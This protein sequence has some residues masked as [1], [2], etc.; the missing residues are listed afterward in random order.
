MPLSHD[1]IRT[2]V[3]TYL[4]HH[5][6]ER[7]QLG[8]FL[9]ALDREADIAC[10]STFSGHVTCGAIVVDHLGRVLHVLHLASGK[11][12]APGGH[13]EP[14][15]ESLAGVALRELHEET[16]IPPD[17]VAPWPGYEDV[18]F[19]VDIHD[20]DARPGKGEPG[21]QHFDV[22]FLF[23]VRTAAEVPVV[24]QEEEVGGIEWR[25]LDRVASP[26]LREKLMKLTPTV[27]PGAS[28][29][30]ALIHNDRGEYLL[31]LRDYL[32]GQIWEPGMWSLLGGGREHQ[33]TTLEQTVRRELAEEAGLDIPDL[34]PFGTEYATDAAGT[35]VP[36][37]IYAGRWNGDPRE[38]RLTEG[39][40]LAWFAPADLHRLRIASTTSDLVRRHAASS[41][42]GTPTEGLPVPAEE[43][44]TRAWQIYGRSQ[45]ARAYTPPVPDQLS[46]TSWEGVGPGAEVLG[47]IA[48]R[49]VL[50]IGSGAGH[51]AVHLARAHGARVT[52][53][54]LS[55]TQH[56]RAVSTHTGHDG[57]EFVQGDVADYLAGAEPFHAAYAIGTL[58]FI[59]PHRSLPALRD[60]LRP[61]APLILSLLHTDLHGRGPSTEVA[62]REQMILLRDDPPLPTQMWVLAPHLW[63]DLLTEYG[64]RVEAID[65]L[66]H[67]DENASVIQQLIRA[68]RLPARPVR[69]SSRPR[70]PVAHAAVGVGAIIVS[71][72]GLLLGRHHRGTIEL[73]GGTVETGESF[74][75]AAVRELGEETGL[76]A[77]SEDVQLLGT[78][79]DH[80]EGVLRV[81]VGA[82]VHVWQGQPATQPNESIGEWAWYPLDQLPDGLFVCSAQILTAW[83]P[84]LNID[85]TP[86]HFTPFAHGSQP[87]EPVDG[88]L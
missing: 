33:D 31:H 51:H 48:G 2:A 12:L 75:A 47:D 18:P 70:P 42:A 26:S 69:V 21:H 22:R 41:P 81:T 60:S 25:P 20:I 37:A 7:P 85:H 88:L 57:V 71:E 19:D 11:V 68:R 10:R 77:R 39:V 45:L 35:A 17:A 50:D 14:K 53:I 23:R 56:E 62:P 55:P 30:S 79:L 80:V 66:K 4:A 40:M 78:L 76:T 63:E 52:G 29:A 73:P 9:E 67:P 6:H 49:R 16:G 28:N 3:E 58:A 38:L 5:P 44:N 15:D 82:L 34:T 27:E 59:D 74:E 54:E 61:G 83:R 86:A 32:P 24:L 84:D 72:Q 13:A 64:F 8:G 87:S 46:W 43:T 1:H 36:I 65:V